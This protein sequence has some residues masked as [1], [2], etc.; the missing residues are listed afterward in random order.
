M[1]QLSPF[2]ISTDSKHLLDFIQDGRNGSQEIASRLGQT[3]QQLTESQEAIKRQQ[4]QQQNNQ[5]RTSSPVRLSQE[6]AK[7]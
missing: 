7:D 6:M 5:Q 2:R 1:D 4:Q 3:R